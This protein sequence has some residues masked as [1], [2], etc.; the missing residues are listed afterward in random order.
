M[1]SA[2][3]FHRRVFARLGLFDTRYEV[4]ADLDFMVR[5]ALSE[6]ESAYTDRVVMEYRSHRGSLTFGR[7]PDAN[8]YSRERLA[9]LSD[10]LRKRALVGRD[11]RTLR[12]LHSWQC[13]TA[14]AMLPRPRS[15]RDGARFLVRGLA[16]DPLFAV[17]V[18]QF[19]FS[20]RR[21]GNIRRRCAHLLPQAFARGRGEH[22][23]AG[24]SN[25]VTFGSR[26]RTDPT[27][28]HAT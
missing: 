3:L 17:R 27:R 5:L 1:I 6:I 19:A 11:R 14:I 10:H 26:L 16:H 25:I 23:A 24:P 18:L 15:V 2:R 28:S 9:I 12:R 21:R 13:C 4:E 22:P 20:P 7:Y 8:I